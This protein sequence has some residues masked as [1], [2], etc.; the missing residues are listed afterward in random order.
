MSI[1]DDLDQLDADI[2]D[3]VGVA[4]LFQSGEADPIACVVEPFLPEPELGLIDARTTTPD[5][6]FVVRKSA[7]PDAPRK[8]DTF[9]I[10]APPALAGVWRAIAAKQAVDDDDGRRWTV[11]V[12][13]VTPPAEPTP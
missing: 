10:A 8:G 6:R 13:R 11:P 1:W 7:L 3:A 5:V 9:T 2:E 4:A 12:A